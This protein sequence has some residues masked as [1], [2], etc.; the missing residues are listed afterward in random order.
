MVE[1]YTEDTDNVVAIEDED[2]DGDGG[3][4]GDK[5]SGSEDP[6]LHLESTTDRSQYTV[7]RP[8]GDPLGQPQSI[9]FTDGNQVRFSYDDQGNLTGVN[10]TAS[11]VTMQQTDHG[12]L[13]TNKDGSYSYVQGEMSVDPQTGAIVMSMDNGYTVT[14]NP[15]GRT[16]ITDDKGNLVGVSNPNYRVGSDNS[17]IGM[18]AGGSAAYDDQ[19][20]M[21]RATN[22][23]GTTY[24]ATGNGDWATLDDKGNLKAV[25]GEVKIDPYR[26]VYV[27]PASQG[28]RNIQK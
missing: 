9:T 14:T 18:R 24:V 2:G 20:N 12:W 15:D 16:N 13:V 5:G 10:D 8:E 1:G 7:D 26:G 4:G 22:V 19:G 6:P 11:G 25:D 21:I 17:Y 3:D 27:V 23:D 28:S